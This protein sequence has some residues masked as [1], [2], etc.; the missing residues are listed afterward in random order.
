MC[1]GYN[2][3][4]NEK[5][6]DL[7]RQVNTVEFWEELFHSF[8]IL[9]PMVPILLAAMESLIPAL[10]LIAIVTLNVAAH[11]PLL[12]FVY[13]WLGA[14][15]GSTLVF[16]FFRRVFKKL[17]LKAAH[18]FPKIGKAREWVN[19]IRPRTLFLILIMPF[20]PSSFVNFSF[21]VSDFDEKQ[22]IKIMIGAKIVMLT[23]LSLFGSSMVQALKNPKYI[24]LAV[25][26]VLIFYGL[27]KYITKRHH[28]DGK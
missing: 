2:E 20:T 7:F 18:R 6:L 26:L 13:S 5:L 19:S 11:G 1:S 16:L 4:M 27:S 3:S 10:P 8:R 22:Y 23:L 14:S 21:G 24:I 12:G 9:G 25:F 15:L 17:V 28:I